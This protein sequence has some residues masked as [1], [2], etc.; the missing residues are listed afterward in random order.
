MAAAPP[1]P[2]AP[3]R[4]GSIRIARVAGIPVGIQPLW[5][6]IVGLITWS[7]GAEYFPEEAPGIEPAA[8]YGL[9]LASALLLFAGILAHEF[10]H[11]LVARRHGVHIDEID[12][13]LLGG[14][15]R[16]RDE[17]TSAHAELRFAIAGPMVTVVIAA[18][19]GVVRLALGSSGPEWLRALIDY[20]L[21]INGAIL[22][23]N[24]LPAFPLDGGRVLRA[25]LWLRSGDQVRATARAGAVGRVFGWTFV[26]LGLLGISS[27][28]P[29]GIWTALIGGFLILA[30]RAETEHLRVE[31]TL[32]GRRVED[33]MSAP[34]QVVGAASTVEEAVRDAFARHL[35]RAFP[36]V[37]PD[38][39]ALGLLTLADARRVPAGR[40][41]EVLV[42]HIADRDPEL[43]VSGS[44]PLAALVARPG[45]A[46]TGRAVVV[47]PAGEPAGI[48]SSSD[49]QRLVAAL[50][51]LDG[52]SA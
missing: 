9:G 11:A 16:M 25:L 29:A 20:Q 18:A 36:V 42:G 1:R 12:L 24:L 33:V 15:A 47:G 38:G 22:A 2:A 41:P 51:L 5:L 31:H 37:D 8:A 48:V 46:R 6:A 19:F 52:S 43:F 7:L 21:Y 14:V 49:V 13:W 26:F 4:G 44:E 45:F 34:V 40:R 30:G 39:R 35:H 3:A 27:G 28:A 10:G 17:P 23:L 50:E 32:E